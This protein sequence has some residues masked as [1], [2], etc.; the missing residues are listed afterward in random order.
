ML[1]GEQMEKPGREQAV[2][3]AK[4][5]LLG[6]LRIREDDSRE[7]VSTTQ[8]IIDGEKKQISLAV[9]EFMSTGDTDSFLLSLLPIHYRILYKA[10]AP[11]W[12]SHCKPVEDADSEV[13]FTY[14]NDLID[15]Y[16][17]GAWGEWKTKGRLQVSVMLPPTKGLMI[18]AFR[19]D[20]K[21]LRANGLI[22]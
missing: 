15:M 5:F 6:G 3:M 2:E 16:W 20:V 13:E 7:L 18:M 17:A 12:L 4:S 19:D 10:Y 11:Y 14:Y 1:D 21:Q 9:K 8:Q 22:D